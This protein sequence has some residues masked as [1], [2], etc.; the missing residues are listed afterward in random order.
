MYLHQRL[1][2]ATTGKQKD[3]DKDNPSTASEAAA[4]S[5]VIAASATVVTTISKH[6]V[7]P[8]ISYLVYSMLGQ[9]KWFLGDA[10]KDRTK[11][12]YFFWLRYDKRQ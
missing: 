9:V 1:A 10:E 7:S 3:D 6:K 2:P 11:F 12:D 8:R 4:A 5:A